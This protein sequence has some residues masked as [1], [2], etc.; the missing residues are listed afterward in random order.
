MQQ[1]AVGQAAIPHFQQTALAADVEHGGATEHPHRQDAL[2]LGVDLAKDLGERMALGGHAIE[3]LGQR[4]RTDGRRQSVAGEVAEH[5]VHAARRLVGRQQQVT[6]EQCVGRLQVAYV[7]R[8]QAAGMRH[9]VEH[10]LGHVLLAQQVLVVPGNQVALLQ[11]RVVQAAQAIHGADLGFQDHPVVGLG[12]KVV[13]TGLQAANQRLT[14]GQRGE[15]DDRNQRLAA[16]LLDPPGRLEAIHH[17]HQRVHQH[18]VR[19]FQLEQGDR[20]EAIAGGRHAMPLATDDGR[21]QHA[22]GRVVLGNQDRQTI[23][24]AQVIWNNCSKL[25]IARILRTSLLQL[26]RRISAASPPAWSR[27][28]RS[29]PSAELSR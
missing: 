9:L 5:H 10:R 19:T 1:V 3:H 25:E 23:R 20:L 16:L 26:S 4:H 11:H 21:Q 15:K 28:S 18:Q 14:L 2:E 12:E 8:G 24:H 27:S 22:I 6:V 17:W 7:R 13:A 29:M